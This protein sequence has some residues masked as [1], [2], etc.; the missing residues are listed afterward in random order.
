MVLSPSSSTSRNGRPEEERPPSEMMPL[1]VILRLALRDEVPGPGRKNSCAAAPEAPRKGKAIRTIQGIL[2]FIRK[3]RAM[4]AMQVRKMRAAAVRMLPAVQERM[5]PAVRLPDT[6][7]S[8][9]ARRYSSL[10]MPSSRLW[11]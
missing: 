6:K 8:A 3:M 1:T 4:S 2:L 7:S 5:Y 10:L 9:A 11:I